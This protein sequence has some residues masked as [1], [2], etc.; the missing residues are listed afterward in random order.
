MT[1]TA[2]IDAG[3][4][5]IIVWSDGS[6]SYIG[7][8]KITSAAANPLTGDPT[9]M[10]ELVGVIASTSGVMTAAKFEFVA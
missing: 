4:D 2:N 1:L 7:T 5:L 6:N 8:Y 10:V 9:T 3:D